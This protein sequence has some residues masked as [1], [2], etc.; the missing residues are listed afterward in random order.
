VEFEDFAVALRDGAGKEIDFRGT[1][2]KPKEGSVLMGGGFEGAP[3][4]RVDESTMLD[5]ASKRAVPSLR[6]TRV[7]SSRRGDT[8]AL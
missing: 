5:E 7:F 3:C 8:G 6:L 2:H 1:G 4:P